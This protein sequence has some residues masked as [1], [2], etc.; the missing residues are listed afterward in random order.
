MF[1]IITG[2][3]HVTNQ[4]PPVYGSVNGVLW[5]LTCPTAPK[6]LTFDVRH[7]QEIAKRMVDKPYNICRDVVIKVSM[8]YYILNSLLD[9]ICVQMYTYTTA[10]YWFLRVCFVWLQ[11]CGPHQGPSYICNWNM[12]CITNWF[13]Q[14]SPSSGALPRELTCICDPLCA[15]GHVHYVG[16]LK[17]LTQSSSSSL[18]SFKT[19]PRPLNNLKCIIKYIIIMWR[20]PAPRRKP[21]IKAKCV[22][23]KTHLCFDI[24][25]ATVTRKLTRFQKGP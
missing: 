4:S 21:V 18:R 10:L 8:L 5:F 24:T 16:Q 9:M 20:L 13:F 6:F 11:W 14:E 22:T 25:Q 17:R 7:R 15:T 23:L 2:N 19:S 3:H 1:W 12:I